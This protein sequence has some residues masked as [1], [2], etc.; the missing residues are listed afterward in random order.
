M[1]YKINKWKNNKKIRLVLNCK[2]VSY[3]IIENRKSKKKL[4]NQGFSKYNPAYFT[5]QV[6]MTEN[7]IL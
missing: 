2:S 3:R 6:S 5:S 1:I 7:I 4:E